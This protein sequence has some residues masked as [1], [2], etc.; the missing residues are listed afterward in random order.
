MSTK[1]KILEQ[2]KDLFN[3]KGVQTTTL[4]QIASAL[5]MSQ[6]N[7]NYH[8]KTKQDIIEQLYFDLVGE[9]N[10]EMEAMTQSYSSLSTLY[11]SSEITMRIFYNYRFLLRDLYLIFRENQVVKEHYIKLQELRKGQFTQLFNLM[12]QE[13]ILRPEELINEYDRLYERMMIVGDNWVNTSELFSLEIKEPVTYYRDL[14]FEMVY[15][16]L[17]EKGKKEF[18]DLFR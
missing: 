13:S 1:E 17:T 6:G 3:K 7:L 16:Y 14:L 2:S 18:N 8:F 5:G 4:R 11:K 12:I 10:K 15:P 9:L